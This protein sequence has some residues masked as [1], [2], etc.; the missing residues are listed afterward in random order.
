MN[1][2][3][4]CRSVTG[5][6]AR[7]NGVVLSLLAVAGPARNAYAQAA[8]IELTPTQVGS[9]STSHFS[10]LPTA[11][12]AVF[13]LNGSDVRRVNFDQTPS[14]AAIPSG[15]LLT[16]HYASFGVTM[17]SI[18]VSNSVYEG[19][20]SPPNATFHNSGHV[21]TFTV[22]VVAAGIINTSPDRDFVELWTGPNRTGQRILQFR[23]QE[24]A[25][26]PN[27][28]IDRFVGGRVTAP[29][30]TIGS[31]F[32]GNAAGDDELDELIFEV[33]VPPCHSDFDGDGDFGTDA[34]IEAYFRCLAGDC[35]A[36]CGSSDFN[37]DGDTGTDADIEAFFRALAGGP[38][39]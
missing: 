2:I 28:H 4:A 5:L 7:L 10:T 39:H 17:N 30:M 16:N 15:T 27:F 12:P 36:S 11:N 19:P 38:C 33:G 9:T 1:Q 23:D 21:F 34:D 22:P 31:M 35:C 20:A 26:A 8:Q 32:V 29:G 18:R 6:I 14:G 37:G 25:P 13:G 24:P 3:N